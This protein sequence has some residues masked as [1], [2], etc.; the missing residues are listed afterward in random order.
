MIKAINEEIKEEISKNSMQISFSQY[1]KTVIFINR[2][3]KVNE[4]KQTYKMFNENEGS[5]EFISKFTNMIVTF[6]EDYEMKELSEL[7][8]RTYFSD[9]MEFKKVLWL[10]RAHY[11]NPWTRVENMI[12]KNYSERFLDV[13]LYFIRTYSTYISN[14]KIIVKL[15]KDRKHDKGKEIIL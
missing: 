4:T 1:F 11:L 7:P 3:H 12:H 8:E 10:D 14:T 6:S 9:Q 15:F 5:M 2:L 13:Y